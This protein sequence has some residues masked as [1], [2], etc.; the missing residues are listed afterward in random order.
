MEK[1]LQFTAMEMKSKHTEGAVIMATTRLVE[2]VLQFT[3]M[4]MKSKNTKG[5]IILETT[6][7]VVY[8]SM[9]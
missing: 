1:V 5:A 7:L 6:R 8:V 4:G 2:K 9:Q 3:V